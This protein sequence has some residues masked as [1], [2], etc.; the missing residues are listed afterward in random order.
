MVNQMNSVHDFFD[1]STFMPHGHCFLWQPNILWLHIISDTGIA[2]AY[3]L[4]PLLLF[5]LVRQRKDLPYKP[6]F[7]A[8]SSFILL[9]G[10]THL[11]AIWV[12]WHPDY[13]LEGVIKAL[14]AI[15][16]ISTLFILWKVTPPALKLIL[17]AEAR[18]TQAQLQILANLLPQLVW[19]ADETGWIYW[20]NDR[21]FEYTGTTAKDM[22][23]W[24]W[25]SVHDP[26]ILQSVMDKWSLSIAT[27]K[28]FEMVFPLRGADGSFRPFLTRVNPVFDT[29]GKVSKWLGTN[30][31]IT[32]Q[33]EA[34][35]IAIEALR[36][37]ETER[38][39]LLALIEN[40][41]DYIGMSDIDGNLQYH[42]RAARLLIGLPP[43]CDLSGL[44]ISD[45]H[46]AWASE[47][48]LEEALPV[49]YEQGIWKGETALLHRDGHEIPVAQTL[50]LYRAS[51][52]TPLCI[53]TIMQDISARR[54]SEE[55]LKASEL[56]LQLALRG[57]GVGMW[58]WDVTTNK[59]YWS[60]RF[61]ELLG[62]QP[63]EFPG[64][65]S[66]WESRLH[67]DD[68]A[69]T[70]AMLEQHLA[71]K[72]PYS[73]D[74]RLLSKSGTWR[75]YHATG[76]AIWNEHQQPLRMAGS[77]DDITDT[78]A[79][80]QALKTSEETFRSAMESASIGM[81]VV[82]PT[83]QFI[84]VNSALCVMLGYSP[85][86][87]LGI[88]FQSITHEDDMEASTKLAKDLLAGLP[89][90]NRIWAGHKDDP[91][92]LQRFVFPAFQFAL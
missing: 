79:Q 46:P 78:K 69:A 54:A 64:L 9:C 48:I 49:L 21:W 34:E 47:H 36:H 41:P 58:D 61:K 37:E 92:G 56:T 76:Q 86:D 8:F 12:L 67:P 60:D 1:S 44:K 26:Q 35:A 20:Y 73:V 28:P 40:S 75:W 91:I 15:V 70:F 51:D 7:A 13:A 33:Y 6:L 72:S 16:S 38:T 85:E 19:T 66:E 83:R 30:T 84:K 68:K 14:T 10:T 77:L 65:F 63:H 50:T 90:S 42:N 4:I 25:Q 32:H 45:M 27:G 82:A 17:P 2:F 55:A 23:G 31:D 62:F 81:A 24:G 11:L 59:I 5:H 74:Y 88:D 18:R 3:F 71:G 29:N 43:D 39:K 53:T 89:T 80:Q 87:M 22:E 52:G 57:T